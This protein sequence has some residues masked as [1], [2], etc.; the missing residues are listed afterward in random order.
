M[1]QIPKGQVVA[2]GQAIR[3]S[4]AGVGHDR[5]R[6]GSAGPFTFAS[7]VTAPQATGDRADER[8]GSSV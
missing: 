2:R 1:K 8:R 5:E 3:V 6:H 4:Y 7:P